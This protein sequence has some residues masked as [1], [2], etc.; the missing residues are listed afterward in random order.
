MVKQQT[1]CCGE[2]STTALRTDSP[3]SPFT[4]NRELAAL[5]S[6]INYAR[7]EWKWDIQYPVPGRKLREPEGRVRW[8]SKAEAER[9]LEAASLEPKATHLPDFLRL[10]LHTG[11]R[12]G[13]IAGVGAGS[14][15]P[16]G[17]AH[18]PGGRPHQN[19][20]TPERYAHLAPENVRSA[21][22]A[23]ESTEP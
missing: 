7:R 8:L 21:V 11:C 5:S 12:K 1:P 9:L 22:M 6:A 13:E 17:R 23:P 14:V 3:S 20:K 15:R 10:A 19:E 4:I 2:T 18:L 16:S